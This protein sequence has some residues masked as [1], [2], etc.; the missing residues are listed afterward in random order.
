M[1]YWRRHE[2]AGQGR[3]EFGVVL[4]AALCM[5]AGGGHGAVAQCPWGRETSL[6]ELQSA[7]LCAINLSQV[8]KMQNGGVSFYDESCAIPLLPL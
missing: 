7:C 3:R 8:R 4:M 2:V 5:M 6:V 1:L